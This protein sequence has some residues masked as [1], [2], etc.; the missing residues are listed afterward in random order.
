MTKIGHGVGLSVEPRDGRWML[1]WRQDETQADGTVRRVQ[2]SKTVY[3]VEELRHFTAAIEAAVRAQGWWRPDERSQAM[4]LVA[5][6]EMAALDWIAWKVGTRGA[7]DNTRGALARSMKR[8]FSEMRELLGLGPKD[9]V[10][11]TALTTAN[12]NAVT[13]RWRDRFSPG[14]IYQTVSA[15]VDMWGWIA[16]EPDRYPEVPRPP[17][18]KQRVLPNRAVYEAPEAVPTWE[19]TDACVRRIRLPCP[20][21]LATIMRYTGLRLEQ[22]V[23]VHREDLDVEHA[24]LLIRKGKSRR[25]QALMR[26]VPVSRHLIAD[27]GEWLVN[28]PGGPLFPDG[29]LVD[30]QG[31]AVPI[32]SYRNQT[33][34]VTE[35]WEAATV[36][37]EARREVW[38][39]PSRLKARPDHAFRAALQAALEE[40]GH[41][42]GVV[43]WLVGHAA[44]TTR[45]KHYARPADRLLRA[46]V[47]GIPAIDRAAAPD[48][49]IPMKRARS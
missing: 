25:E 47:D 2:R 4:P 31:K 41:A 9:G 13:A 30:A 17:H 20:R 44:R 18:S 49:V 11:V 48:N 1:R 42:E 3:T 29:R 21:R 8:F 24:T 27:L 28:H 22:A 39:P 35:A 14:T 33:R 23:H 5:N 15:V 38:A 36:A 45:A 7:A 10:P 12:L 37:E 43:D 6:A 26:R 40:G 16:D 46:A 32:R 19:E 34:Y